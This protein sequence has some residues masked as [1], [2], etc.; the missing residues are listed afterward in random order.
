MKKAFLATTALA[1]GAVMAHELVDFTQSGHNW[2]AMN[3]VANAHQ[4]ATGYVFD[5]TGADPWCV[6]RDTYA[7][8]A[9]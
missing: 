7:M 6:S 4:A 8:P 9:P 1:V 3:H 2:N 5:V